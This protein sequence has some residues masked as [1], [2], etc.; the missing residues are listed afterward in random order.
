ML[1]HPRSNASLAHVLA[2]AASH[3][4]VLFTH[5]LDFGATLASSGLTGPSVI[6][7]RTRDI[8]P[9]GVG[10]WVLQAL[11]DYE[12]HLRTGARLTLDEE[13]MRVRLLPLRWS[14]L[15]QPEGG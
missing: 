1:P 3:G 2:W 10:A 6:Q 9:E 4:H 12:S 13:S 15:G 8:T 5:D 11:G 14:G 7:V